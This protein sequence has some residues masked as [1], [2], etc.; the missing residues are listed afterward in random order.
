LAAFYVT[1]A[2]PVIASHGETTTISV[3]QNWVANLN[4]HVWVSWAVSAGAVGYG[5]NERRLRRKE[6]SEK[7][8]RITKLEQA[9]DPGRTSSG[10]NQ[11]GDP[12]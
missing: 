11:S 1:F 10:V 9:I 4:A 8:A 12:Q 3:A 6:R 2:L 5:L 7:D